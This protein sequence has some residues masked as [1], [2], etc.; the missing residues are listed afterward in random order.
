MLSFSF[1]PTAAE[2]TGA[3]A[4]D[5]K[6]SMRNKGKVKLYPARVMAYDVAVYVSLNAPVK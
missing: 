1:A 6:D 3:A 4:G 2:I 5:A